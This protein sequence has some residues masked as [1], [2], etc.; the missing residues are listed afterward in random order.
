LG[1]G[2]L[3]QGLGLNFVL[4]DGGNQNYAGEWLGCLGVCSGDHEA[5][6]H[7]GGGEFLN[8][9]GHLSYPLELI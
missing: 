7:C 6:E 5:S 3:L 9:V 4:G 2:C 8:Q 1:L